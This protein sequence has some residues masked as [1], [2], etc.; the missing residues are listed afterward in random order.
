MPLSDDDVREI[1]RLIDESD[2]E[3][4]RVET[5]RFSLH[6]VAAAASLPSRAEPEPPCRRARSR[7]PR[8][9]AATADELIRSRRR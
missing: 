7:R 2:V 8:R 5:E 9:G 4:L 1:L 3:E 6:V